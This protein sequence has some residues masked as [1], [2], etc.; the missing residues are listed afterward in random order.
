MLRLLVT[1]NVVRSS[2]T[3][4]TLD[5]GGDTILRN[6]GSYKSNTA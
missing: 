3:L 1:A 2:L 5:D 6:F 4:D